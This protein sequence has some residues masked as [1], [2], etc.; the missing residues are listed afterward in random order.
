MPVSA[1][2]IPVAFPPPLESS[3]APT[4]SPVS[5]RPS[6]GVGFFEFLLGIAL[7]FQVW[8]VRSI[9]EPGTRGARKASRAPLPVILLGLSYCP[10]P[11]PELP[12]PPLPPLVPELPA[13][14]LPPPVL[15]PLLPAPPALPPPVPELPAPPLP[16][17][18]APRLVPPV[19][20]GPPAPTLSVPEVPLPPVPA[21]PLLPALS[22][23]ELPARPVPP[24]APV[25]P[26]LV[27][28]PEP[29]VPLVVPELVPP[30]PLE[31][32]DPPVPVV[33][34]APE[35]VPLPVPLPLPLSQPMIVAPPNANDAAAT[36]TQRLRIRISG[37]K[38]CSEI[39]STFRGGTGTNWLDFHLRREESA[40]I[41]FLTF[42]KDLRTFQQ[43][44]N[45]ALRPHREYTRKNTSLLKG[46][47]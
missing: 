10:A 47:P 42:D 38:N 4:P 8:I 36:N 13:P 30:V 37:R 44:Q 17:L 22:V 6:P 34:L 15:P 31:P 40:P 28:A 12:A 43:F 20:P 21:V 2:G 41:V 11:V 32:P 35:P 18:P 16:P 7:T 33:P 24:V 14:P 26:E 45:I 46:S 29:P 25:A 19:L 39:R 27:P 3:D 1:S 9:R 5:R 23:P